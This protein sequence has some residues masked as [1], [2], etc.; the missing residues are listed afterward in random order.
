MQH[1]KD[2][3]EIKLLQV[4][5]DAAWDATNGR[6]YHALEMECLEKDGQIVGLK[7][8][9]DYLQDLLKEVQRLRVEY[10]RPRGFK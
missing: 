9:E 8:R 2:K 10:Q 6:K 3:A 4:A 5:A 7:Q 1:T